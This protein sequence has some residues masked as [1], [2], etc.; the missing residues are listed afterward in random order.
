MA[1]NGFIEGRLRTNLR[2]SSL[3]THKSRVVQ[4][5][6]PVAHPNEQFGAERTYLSMYTLTNLAPTRQ[7]KHR[8]QRL[9]QCDSAEQP[10]TTEAPNIYC[11]SSMPDGPLGGREISHAPRSDVRGQV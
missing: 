9:Q 2:Y 3:T 11:L 7:Y 10:S 4:K 1:L 8:I 6:K 5:R